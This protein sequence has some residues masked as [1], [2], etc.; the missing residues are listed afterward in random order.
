[1]ILQLTTNS[2]FMLMTLKNLNVTVITLLTADSYCDAQE[3]WRE[4][5]K[6]TSF[7]NAGA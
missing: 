5:H 6:P 7:L 3:T 4:V 2:I 1:M